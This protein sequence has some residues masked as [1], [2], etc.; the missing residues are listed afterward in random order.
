MPA[1]L[2]SFFLPFFLAPTHV[3]SPAGVCSLEGRWRSQYYGGVGG[4]VLVEDTLTF[5][6]NNKTFVQVLQPYPTDACDVNSLIWEGT[7]NQLNQTN[8]RMSFIY[9]ELSQLGCLNC[10]P[11]GDFQITSKFQ[12][13]C[14]SFTYQSQDE[15]QGV[16]TYYQLILDEDATAAAGQLTEDAEVTPDEPDVVLKELEI[17]L[18]QYYDD[19]ADNE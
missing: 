2:L 11:S 7:Y 8:F 19:N 14:S 16:R 18:H 17:V 5:E 6:A 13:D 10:T 4:D 12:P 3:F 15:S 1:Q 9:C